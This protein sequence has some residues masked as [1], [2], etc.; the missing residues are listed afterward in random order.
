MCKNI[1]LCVDESAP[2]MR[3]AGLAGELARCLA[4]DLCIL[5]CF[6]PIPEYLGQPNLQR[7][8]NERIIQA[9]KVIAATKAE[10]G[11]IPGV[12]STEILEGVLPKAS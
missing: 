5:T 4:S 10:L 12:L 8:I 7:A 1:L 11:E 2:A 3:A 9:E 6:E